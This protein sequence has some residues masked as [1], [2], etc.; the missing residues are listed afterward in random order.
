[1]S[2]PGWADCY[3]GR[4]VL[5]T[6]HSGFKGGWLVV[7]LKKLGARVS[8]LAL[9]PARGQ[10]ALFDLAGIGEGI[11][12]NFADIRDAEAVA[13]IVAR[14]QPEVVFH[15][16]AQPLVRASYHE[17]ALT[18]MTNVMGT[19]HLLEAVR[20]TPSVRA[21]VN[22]TSDKCYD[23][24]ASGRGHSECDPMGGDDPYSSSKGAAELVTAAYRRSYFSDD[25]G[26]ALASARAGNVFGGGDWAA[27]RLVPDIVRAAASGEALRLRH[28]D[29]IRP[30]QHVL[31]PL[32][33]YLL[34]GARLG[35]DRQ[36]Y[37]EGWNFAPDDASAVTVAE[38]ARLWSAAWGPGGPSIEI[39]QSPPH[40][41]ETKVLRLDA[42]KA[43]ARLGWAPQFSLDDAVRLTVKWYRSYYQGGGSMR[44]FTERQI[45]GYMARLTEEASR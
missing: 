36:A 5:V 7:W 41:P 22:V 26:P 27:D 8:G 11:A 35:A 42:S 25:G 32:Y 9:E 12:S 16:A 44:E 24:R 28:P 43:R 10:P 1:M 29:A 31:E 21:V 15:L 14:H 38:L 4:A 13:T 3:R 30:W 23:S 18:Y 40:V 20:R 37:A 2:E 6:G 33:G 19:V 34:L 45:A 39:D 17:P